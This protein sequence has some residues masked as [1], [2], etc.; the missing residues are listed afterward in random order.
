[1]ETQRERGG[2]AVESTA[3]LKTNEAHSFQSPG[4]VMLITAKEMQT[5][6][7]GEKNLWVR[8]VSFKRKEELTEQKI[9]S[10]KDKMLCICEFIILTSRQ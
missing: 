2:E 9:L 8:G 6:R 3:K 1:M 5:H 7:H 4:V 10:V